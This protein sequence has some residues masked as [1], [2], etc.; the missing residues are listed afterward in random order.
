MT[1]WILAAMLLGGC[2]D[3]PPVKGEIDEVGPDLQEGLCVADDTDEQHPGTLVVGEELVEYI[4]T[5]GD[6]DWYAFDIPAATPLVVYRLTTDVQFTTVTYRLALISDAGGT[7]ASAV[8]P[9]SGR[10][11]VNLQGVAYATAGGHRVMVENVNGIN[12]D[13]VNPYHLRVELLADPDGGEPND[14]ADEAGPLSGCAEGFLAFAGDEDWFSFDVAAGQVVTVRLRLSGEAGEIEPAYEIRPEGSSEAM[15]GGQ[16]GA[17]HALPAGSYRLRVHDPEGG[18]DLEAGY[19][20]CVSMAAETDP[21]EGDERN[22]R[23][24]DSSP[25]LGEQ[26][27][28]TGGRIGSLGDRD[29]YRVQPPEGTSAATPA[30]FEARVQLEAPSDQG[31][32]LALS[33]V[34]S[35]PETPCAVDGDCLLLRGACR[36]E[37]D[38]PS[39]V[40][41]RSQARCAGAGVC[42]PEGVCGA[43]VWSSTLE[44]FDADTTSLTVRAPIFDPGDHWLLVHDFQDDEWDE[45]V[46]Y[47]VCWEALQETDANEP[48]GAWSPY[49]REDSASAAGRSA[50]RARRLP[51]EVV[52]NDVTGE[53]E[54]VR[55]PCARGVISYPGDTDWFALPFPAEADQ[56]TQTWHFEFAYT[57]SGSPLKLQY[58][59]A[60]GSAGAWSTGW[61]EGAVGA[62]VGAPIPATGVFGRSECAYACHN[63]PRPFWLMVAEAARAGWDPDNSYEVC[64]TAYPGCRPN[65]CPCGPDRPVNDNQCPERDEQG[66][67]E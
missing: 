44:D 38:C 42:L 31:L 48:N 57:D 39:F 3:E 40:C 43:T 41:D 67:D 58:L 29:W 19:E 54:A 52:R 12:T 8:D 26:G 23:P 33:L 36:G 4:C 16:E 18:S 14:T 63:L 24:G 34:K 56:P 30:V 13:E 60:A 66:V 7:V 11:P 6:Q 55:F 22:D 28:Q 32:E 5:P 27:C 25:D 1:R 15:A 21:F 20:I 62:G 50:D 64:L 2:E 49:G 17:A 9:H 37:W 45:Q 47:Q 10:R 59:V 51:G 65:L 46:P 53:L 35:N 61:Q